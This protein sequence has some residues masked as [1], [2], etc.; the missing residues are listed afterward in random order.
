MGFMQLDHFIAGNRAMCHLLT[1]SV[2]LKAISYL[3]W[4]FRECL[5]QMAVF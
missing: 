4:L 5:D 1:H 2:G 3:L